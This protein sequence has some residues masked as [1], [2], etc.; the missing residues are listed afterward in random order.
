MPKAVSRPGWGPV[1]GIASSLA[2]AAA[3][4]FLCLRNQPWGAALFLPAAW[5][6]LRGRAAE[7]GRALKV[8][9]GTEAG[10]LA[11]VVVLALVLRLVQLQD[12]PNAG[13]RDE[14]ENGNVAIQILHGENVAN[15]ERRFP[16]YLEANTQNATGYMYPV[17][18]A[19]KLFGISITSERYVSVLF[20][21]LSVAAFYFLAR[22]FFGLPLSLL[23]TLVLATLRWHINF[24]RIGFLGIM[25]LFLEIP[26]FY[27][28]WKGL[29]EEPGRGLDDIHPGTLAAAI[30]LAVL[31]GFFDL[32]HLAWFW[33]LPLSWGLQGLLVWLCFK[34]LKDKRASNFMFAGFCLA[35]ALYSYIAARLLVLVV[36]GLFFGVTLLQPALRHRTWR[37]VLAFLAGLAALGCVLLVQGSALA[38]PAWKVLGKG[39]LL[40]AGLGLAAFV[41]L[42]REWLKGW[43][44]PLALAIGATLVVGGPLYNYS[45]LHFKEVSA[46]SDRVSVFN[47]V[48]ADKRA[49]GIKL[50]ENLPKTLG[51]YNVVGDGNPRHNLPGEI[52]LNPG[53]AALFAVGALLCLLQFWKT[54]NFFFLLWWQVT[55]LAGYYSIEAP[56]AYRTIGAIP[57]VLLMAGRAA[58][59]LWSWGPARWKG[60]GKQAAIAL[61]GLFFV[62]G[63]VYECRTYFVRQAQDP[64]VWAEFSTSEFM[65]GHDL[66]A[67]SPHVY[68]LIRPDWADSFTLHF[69]AY[70]LKPH[71]D[72]GYFDPARHVPLTNPG[73]FAGRDV[74]YILDESYHPLLPLLRNFYPSG[75]Y[76]EFHHPMTNDLL[77]WSY[78]VPA[79]EV[80]RPFK[81]DQG[82]DGRYFASKPDGT[83]AWDA[84]HFKFTRRDPF[85][86]FNWTV[87]PVPG[88]FSVEWTGKL[89]ADKAGLYHFFIHSND[90]A[91]LE[92]DGKT[93]VNR[94]HLPEGNQE[95]EGTVE[96]KPGKHALRLRYSEARSYSRMELWW[97]EPGGEKEVV[98]Y[99]AL[100]PQ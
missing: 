63:V 62:G 89:K 94:A 78:L 69:A 99:R 9:R 96:L 98:P 11:A 77:Y 97:Q 54:E 21:V 37:L 91:S 66:E 33:N 42:Q 43:M 35:M 3:G 88:F 80:A 15:S 16:V 30:G 22:L 2:L 41:V 17:A 36:L 13:F 79:A 65:M 76:K 60:F 26:L 61:A 44:K 70:P 72:Y 40:L 20:G 75:T 56:Q 27:F 31:R 52:M 19:F 51:M 68:G 67:L 47:D 18:L 82:L 24:S 83:P 5:I 7:G 84:E 59:T 28:L 93:V 10:L 58:E 86:L 29:H 39:V 81:L 73:Q 92:L 46:R 6:L 64:G 48:E 14:G 85:I 23:L 87:D 71:E 50:K 49:W 34:G 1:L 38:H 95:A 4:Q 8:G 55:L 90:Q 100:L 53:L 12:F 32:S 25:T 57:V 74:L 45:M